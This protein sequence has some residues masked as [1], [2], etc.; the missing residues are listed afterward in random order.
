M[1]SYSHDKLPSAPPSVEV[2]AKAC[3]VG[4]V[5]EVRALLKQEGAAALV[6]KPW[7]FGGHSPLMWAACNGHL[8][9]VRLMVGECRGEP[10]DL[11][12]KVLP[13]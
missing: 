9:V 2:L 7:G 13:R 1:V 5:E 10:V 12:M 6:N 4:K 11:D 3:R 8:G